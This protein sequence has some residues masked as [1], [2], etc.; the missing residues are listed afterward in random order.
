V[1]ANRSRPRLPL[2]ILLVGCILSVLGAGLWHRWLR[3]VA[4]HEISRDATDLEARISAGIRSHIALLRGASGL[5]AVKGEVSRDE[6]HHYVA[7]LALERNYPG[8][9]GIGFTVRVEPEQLRSFTAEAR[10]AGRPDFRVWPDDPRPEYHTILYLEPQ[11]ARNRAAIGYDMHTEPNRRDA[12]DRARDTGQ[13]AATRKVILVQEIDANKQA[14]FLI[15]VPFYRGAELPETIEERRR[16]LVG[17][18]YAPF[19]AGDFVAGVAGGELLGH[20]H[21]E[22][23]DGS[24][25][26][27][28]A[29][30]Y[31]T[32]A[33]QARGSW[34]AV[35]QSRTLHV[36]NQTWTMVY[37]GITAGMV[38]PL[39]ILFGGFILSAGASFLLRREHHALHRA[40]RSEAETRERESELS[41][42]VESVP[43]LV[44]YVDRD[45]VIRLGNRRFREWLSIEPQQLAGQRLE[46]VIGPDLYAKVEPFVRRAI[47]G[48]S[49]SFERWINLESGA[50][51]L[52][53]FLVPHR[54]PDGDLNG[55]YALTSDLT[56]HKRVEDHAAFVADCGKL[57]ISSWDN[58]ST[59]RG[60]VR[61]AVPR[62]ADVAVLFRA[63]DGG[64]QAEAMAHVDGA[65]EERLGAFLS[66]LRLPMDG[67]NNVA[68]AARSGLTM[69]VLEITP[70]SLDKAAQDPRQRAM[71][72][73]LELVSALHVP[74]VVRGQSWGVFSFGTSAGSGRR[75][76]DEDRGLAEEL[77]TR[78]RLAIENSLLYAEAQLE[79]EE[80]RRAERS[81]RETEERFRLLVAG[82]RDYAII[83]L[84]AEGKIASW[85]EGAERIF[86]LTEAEAVNT[87]IGRFYSLEEQHSGLL[88][89]KLSVARATG[90]A[91][92]ERWY[93]RK[94]GTRFWASGHTVVLRDDEGSIRGY[95][96]IVR[97]LTERKL[98]EQELEARV[99]ERTADLNEAVQELESFSYSVSHDLRAPLR[100]IRGFTELAMEEAGSRLTGEERS[101]MARVLRAVD[102]LDELIRDL[103]AY[104][105]V[106]KTKVQLAPVDLHTLVSDLRREHSEFHPPRSEIRIDGTLLPVIGSTAFLTQCMTNL[107]GNATKFVASGRR[108]D[109]RVWT[110]RR[111]AAVRLFV[112]DNGIGIAA[113]NLPRVFEMFE[114]LH[115]SEGYEGTGVGLAI[116]RRAVHRMKGE[117]GVDSIVG[118]G[119]TFW[120]ELPAA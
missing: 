64:L 106:A 15:Y 1:A 45:G 68:A 34:K 56:S 25:R 19:R 100:S 66:G 67:T 62:V 53:T 29:L 114:R 78:M 10:R 44:A 63:R 91:P 27:D 105:R 97:D 4:S 16:R 77:A 8:I 116:V 96:K 42:L 81:M 101:H 12:M 24:D 107:L 37:T 39:A 41:L 52:A 49:V 109:V 99:Q 47:R 26:S 9:Q 87:S 6:F 18:V 33:R 2:K 61:L 98:T 90:S 35:T 43:A 36:A 13:P 86:G 89:Q 70:E 85:N 84:D 57:L 95:A 88:E 119:T 28:A 50:R 65:M 74:V 48:E 72:A 38:S 69:V 111:G 30:L 93:G 23:Y 17:Y 112:R 113:Q 46:D 59:G 51:Y 80:R 58:E 83:L 94:D 22:L 117:V 82:A 7:Q 20:I 73:A 118:E 75:F 71:L 3:T 11:N 108:P 79:V 92:E 103:L 55:F 60:V 54:T 115:A 110:E 31:R 102:R 14:G 104:T 120:I 32:N 40:E 76:T 5:F 21:L